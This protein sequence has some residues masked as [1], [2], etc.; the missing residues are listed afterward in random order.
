MRCVNVLFINLDKSYKLKPT[1]EYMFIVYGFSAN[2]MQKPKNTAFYMVLPYQKQA[3]HFL[4]AY[5]FLFSCPTKTISSSSSPSMNLKID[6]KQLTVREMAINDII[7]NIIL[8][9]KELVAFKYH[10][11]PS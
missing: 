8:T 11:L 3:Y 1:P 5:S 6:Q 4:Q 2:N 9:C 10:F 7:G